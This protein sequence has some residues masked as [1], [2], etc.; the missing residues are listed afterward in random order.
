MNIQHSSRTDRW[1]T[2]AQIILMIKQVL[3][4]IDLD[5]ASEELANK[6]IGAKRIIT[7]KEDG[8]ETEWPPGCTVYLNP[9]GS[10][11]N[12]KSM[13]A[14]FWEKLMEYRRLGGLKHA[15]Y[16]GFSLE[17]LAITQKYHDKKMIEFPL[18]IPSSR[19]KFVNPA[20]EKHSPSHSNVI[21]YVPGSLDKT[22]EF[23]EIFLDIGACKR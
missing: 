16:M 17:Q 7:E 9:P 12:N 20:I 13:S 1:F 22:D 18:C 21:V 19:I 4:E 5:P 3:G 11:R 15:I 23:I 10:K 6:P 14:L 8:L 2:P